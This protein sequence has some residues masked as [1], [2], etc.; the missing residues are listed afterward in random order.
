M[1]H[2]TLIILTP[3]FPEHEGDS[4]CIPPQQVFVKALKETQPELNIVV[5]TF[6]YPF[7]SGEYQW[8]GIRVISFGHPSNSRIIRRFTGIKVLTV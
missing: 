4:T 1:K 7:F 2:K 3:G 8:H 6:Q 5:L